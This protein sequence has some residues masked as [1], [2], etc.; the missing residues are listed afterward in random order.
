MSSRS[1]GSYLYLPDQLSFVAQVW[2]RDSLRSDAANEGG[3]GPV[4]PPASG[5]M[6]VCGGGGHLSPTRVATCQVS[7]KHSSLLATALRLAHHN[8]ANVVGS[9]VLPT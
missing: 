6:G 1:D 5:V 2:Q 3:T 4:L 9:V 8:S 7:N